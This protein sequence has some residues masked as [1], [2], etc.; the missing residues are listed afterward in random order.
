MVL[1]C[2]LLSWLGSAHAAEPAIGGRDPK[3]LPIT[4]AL[5]TAAGPF[6]C[7][8]DPYV[9]IRAGETAAVR[10]RFTVP[11]SE[12]LFKDKIAVQVVDA[13]GLTVGALVLPPA[14][15]FKDPQL[16]TLRDSYDA[17]V[18]ITLPVSAPNDSKGRVDM[19]LAV[20]WQGCCDA[21]ASAA[22]TETFNVPIHVVGR[23]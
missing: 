14:D 4:T 21:P 15:P 20:S 10:I 2:L 16:G 12:R 22:A 18:E 5:T 9:A 1:G 19:T 11:A 8:I 7:V 3:T 17:D 23:R 13:A 6:T